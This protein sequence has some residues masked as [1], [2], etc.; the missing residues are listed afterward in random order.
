MFENWVEFYDWYKRNHNS[1][2]N[3]HEGFVFED[4]DGFMF[5]FKTKYYNDW[6]YMRSIIDSV[7]RNVDRRPVQAILQSNDL[8][9]GFYYWARDLDKEYLKRTDIITLRNK[10][11]LENGE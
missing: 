6:K 10:Y 7:S 3:E 5:K 8:L 9:S 1:L 4:S 2:L 11:L